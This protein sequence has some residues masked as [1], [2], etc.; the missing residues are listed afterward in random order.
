MAETKITPIS[1]FFLKLKIGST[2]ET[3]STA[4]RKSPKNQDNEQGL[5]KKRPDLKLNIK[6]G[7][8]QSTL[9]RWL[10]KPRTPTRVRFHERVTLKRIMPYWVSWT[11]MPLKGFSDPDSAF[12]KKR[13]DTKRRMA[14]THYWRR[15]RPTPRNARR[16]VH[17]LKRMR[18]ENT[19]LGY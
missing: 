9:D 16:V 10:I 1:S 19:K 2:M 4:K 17:I 8:M 3:N 5:K 12:T 18:R 14:H 7:M 6:K 11:R 13:L 15:Q